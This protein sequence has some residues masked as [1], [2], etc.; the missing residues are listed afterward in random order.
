MC[1]LLSQNFFPRP[2]FFDEYS[3]FSMYLNQGLEYSSNQCLTM[4]LWN[5]G[6]FVLVFLKITLAAILKHN[7]PYAITTKIIYPTNNVFML[8]AFHEFNFLL[9]HYWVLNDVMDTACFMDFIFLIATSSLV[10]TFMP[11]YTSAYAPSPTLA[12]SSYYVLFLLLTITWVIARIDYISHPVWILLIL[13]HLIISMNL[14]F[15]ASWMKM[16][17]F[18]PIKL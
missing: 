13:K 2:I 14:P 5:F 6:N 12:M 4:M 11:L 9:S 8:K 18:G 17:S 3:L 7:K 16:P 15:F 1:N 10:A